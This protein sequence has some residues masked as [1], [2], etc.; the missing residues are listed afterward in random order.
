MHILR[1]A[2]SIMASLAH[3]KCKTGTENLRVQFQ[4]R[5][6]IDVITTISLIR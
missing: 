6:L 5:P 2:A 4:L 1:L 3:R